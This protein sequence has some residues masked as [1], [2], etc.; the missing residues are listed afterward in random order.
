M[1]KKWELLLLFL[2]SLERIQLR[3]IIQNLK[4]EIQISRIAPQIYY[5]GLFRRIRLY[6]SLLIFIR[7]FFRLDMNFSQII[8][9]SSSSILNM[10]DISELYLN[11]SSQLM[12]WWILATSTSISLAELIKIQSES[13]F[14]FFLICPENLWFIIL[15]F[16]L[17]F[18]I[19]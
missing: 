3:D 14:I 13:L 5:K 4:M 6:E 12:P 9:K 10:R 15:F 1:S 19:P 16:I 18:P 11:S 2:L 7:S 8:A 17:F